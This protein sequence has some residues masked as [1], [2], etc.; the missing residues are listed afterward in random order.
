MHPVS[1]H[2]KTQSRILFLSQQDT[3][4]HPVSNH[5]KT[6][7]RILF[8][9]Q[10]DTIS[11]PVSNH[12]KTQSRILFLSQ[13]DTISHPVSNHS[14]TQ[15][16]ILFLSQQ[17]TIS[18]PLPITAR[19]N[20]ASCSFIYHRLVGLVARC[21]LGN[22]QTWVQSQLPHR[23]FLRVESYQ[24]NYQDSITNKAWPTQQQQINKFAKLKGFIV[25]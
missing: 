6:Q 22:L 17:D 10:Q 2:S 9:S 12:S 7:S 23:A 15:S 5:S 18:H 16:R 8:L 14:K 1:N 19:H 4:S 20:L 24:H 11:H 3:I 13:Q 25:S 21:P